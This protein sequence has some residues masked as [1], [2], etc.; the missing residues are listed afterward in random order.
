MFGLFKKKTPAAPPPLKDLAIP[1]PDGFTAQEIAIIN[2]SYLL[3]R[4]AAYDLGGEVPSRWNESF[5][6]FERRAPD[7]TLAQAWMVRAFYNGLT[8][9]AF[10]SSDEESK[11]ADRIGRTYLSAFPTASDSI[12]GRSC[13]AVQEAFFDSLKRLDD[14]D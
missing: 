7:R 8:A 14:G 5:S 10:V 9:N 1:Q 13:S 11:V 6:A 12:V 4:S 2:G 3:I